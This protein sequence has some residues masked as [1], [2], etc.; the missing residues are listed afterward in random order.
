MSCNA[1]EKPAELLFELRLRLFLGGL[2]LIDAMLDDL[3]LTA[4]VSSKICHDLVGPV[5]AINNGLELLEEETDDETREYAFQIIQ[6]SAQIAWARLE[7]AR[8][9]F[10]ASAGLGSTIDLGHAERIARAF[11]EE[12]RHRLHWTGPKGGVD[13]HLTRLLL[14]LIAISLPAIPAG[15]DVQ[16]TITGSLTAPVYQLEC[17]GRNARIPELTSDIFAGRPVE[18]LDPRVILPYYAWRLACR[19]GMTISVVKKGADV[20]F[21]AAPAR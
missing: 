10:G 7:Y 16:V 19:S 9:A 18:G 17:R 2:M 6:N 15:G 13:K 4:F 3:D 5:G 12:G 21:T 8:L 11:V 20:I 1:L 14:M